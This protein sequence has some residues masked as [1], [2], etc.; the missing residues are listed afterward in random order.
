VSAG[1]PRKDEI[2]R[3]LQT[4]FASEFGFDAAALTPGTRVMEDLDLD[5]IDFVDMAVAL[6]VRIGHKLKEEDVTRIRTLQDIV[7]VIDAK[8]GAT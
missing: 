2:F 5:S 4:V 8:L 6:E 1:G 7:D 3:E